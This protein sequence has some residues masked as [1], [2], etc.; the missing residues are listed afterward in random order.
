[1][2]SIATPQN[3]FVNLNNRLQDELRKGNQEKY[4]GLNWLYE[5]KG[6]IDLGDYDIE[7]G[8]NGVL[9]VSRQGKAVAYFTP[10]GGYTETPYTTPAD[11]N[12]I[13]GMSQ[14]GNQASSGSLEQSNGELSLSPGVFLSETIKLILES[15]KRFLEFAQNQ[16]AQNQREAERGEEIEYE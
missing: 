14:L 5:N 15:V 11:R 10:E 6:G 16:F 4:Q 1:M 13:T 12:N 7:K 3:P 8:E 9:A 2:S